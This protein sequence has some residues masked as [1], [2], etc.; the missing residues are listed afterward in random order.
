MIDKIKKYALEFLNY[1]EEFYKY[2]TTINKILH[3]S[4]DNIHFS[5]CYNE[6]EPINQAELTQLNKNLDRIHKFANN[7]GYIFNIFLVLSPF[8]KAFKE[9]PTLPLNTFNTNTGFTLMTTSKNK[10]ICVVRKEEYIKVIYHEIIHHILLINSTF[11]NSNINKLKSHFKILN[12]KVDPNEAIIEFWATIMFLKEL[13]L[14]TNKDYYELFMEELNYSLYKSYQINK[15]QKLNGGYWKDDDTN[16][17]S[18][19]IFKT[20]IMYN[21]IEF[22]KI[23]TFPYND[24]VITDFLIKNSN[25]PL[26]TCR[27]NSKR[28]IMSLCFMVNSDS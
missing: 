22:N 24:D 19:V 12:R 23:Y 25:L 18:Y 6:T 28:K 10:L 15:L 3:I 20:I 14:E 16:L 8:K 7:F 13:S 17:Y 11:S 27:N 21:I 4:K 26:K 2:L 1:N 5:V 9:N